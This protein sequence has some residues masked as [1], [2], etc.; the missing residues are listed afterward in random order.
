MTATH[1]TTSVSL[2]Q[3]ADQSLKV[4]DA[5]ASATVRA[6][7]PPADIESDKTQPDAPAQQ[8]RDTSR[9]TKLSVKMGI[10]TLIAALCFT[11]ICVVYRRHAVNAN[12]VAN[13]TDA[14]RTSVKGF[15]Q[16]RST[17]SETLKMGSSAS[18]IILNLES[19]QQQSADTDTPNSVQTGNSAIQKQNGNECLTVKVTI[20]SERCLDE[21]NPHS[22]AGVEHDNSLPNEGSR[23]VG[24]NKALENGQLHG[25]RRLSIIPGDSGNSTNMH[26]SG[27]SRPISTGVPSTPGEPG[28]AVQPMVV[29]PSYKLKIDPIK[30]HMLYFA[31]NTFV[32][33][34]PAQYVTASETKRQLLTTAA[35]WKEKYIKMMG[36]KADLNI[37]RVKPIRISPAVFKTIESDARLTELDNGLAVIN[38][39]YSLKEIDEK[40]DLLSVFKSEFEWKHFYAFFSVFQYKTVVT[41]DE[42][43][44][45]FLKLSSWGGNNEGN[46]EYRIQNTL[47]DCGPLGSP[48]LREEAMIH[49]V[50]KSDLYNALVLM[51]AKSAFVQDGRLVVLYQSLFERFPMWFPPR[52]KN[53]LSFE[54]QFFVDEMLFS[55]RMALKHYEHNVFFAFRPNLHTALQLTLIRRYYEFNANTAAPALVNTRQPFYQYQ[56]TNKSVLFSEFTSRVVDDIPLFPDRNV[57]LLPD[58]YE[59]SDTDDKHE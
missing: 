49:A 50:L 52:S 29:L 56:D 32:S 11:A 23:S 27:P 31:F 8:P 19:K 20:K 33:K 25:T 36:D 55:M 43:L 51:F 57:A 47:F 28:T 38:R 9:K 58:A 18:I 4:L 41:R 17:T 6:E 21:L 46:V 1:G 10:A 2:Q 26:V 34:T 22:I 14:G 54:F 37:Y 44:H 7:P 59:P 35:S 30:Q 45:T 16:N 5:T 39:Q 15:V 3:Q 40:A 13:Q 12:A 42:M 53:S 48:F 24:K